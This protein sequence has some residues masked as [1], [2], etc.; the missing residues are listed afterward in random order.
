MSTQPVLSRHRLPRPY[1]LSL[2][3]LWLTPIALLSLTLLISHGFS[4]ALLDPR[5]LIPFLLMTIPALYIWR[6][7]VDVLPEG[8]SVNQHG[9][10]YHAYTELDNWYYDSHPDKR[11]LTI[12]DSENRKALE[13]RAYLTD[14]PLLLHA[15][16]ENLRPRNW[17]Y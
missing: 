13:C 16:K 9:S 7:G 17:P 12:W 3:A 15:L 2:T 6:E 11:V 4:P 10:H 1:R 5:L 8:L 14:M